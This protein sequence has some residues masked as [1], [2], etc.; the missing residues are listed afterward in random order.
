MERAMGG[1]WQMRLT[2]EER[3]RKKERE[4]WGGGAEQKQHRQDVL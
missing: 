4:G 1:K 2:I 3:K